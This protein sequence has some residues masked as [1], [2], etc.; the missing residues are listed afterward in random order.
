MFKAF[1]VNLTLKKARKAVKNVFLIL[2]GTRVIVNNHADLY[3]S[4]RELLE[5]QS[6]VE[7]HLWIGIVPI[8]TDVNHYI[9]RL[10]SFFDNFQD[11][12]HIPWKHSHKSR[13]H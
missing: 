10:L 6:I 13:R 8:S 3:P 2:C 9:D 12:A 7:K 4:V 5:S 1:T 11:V